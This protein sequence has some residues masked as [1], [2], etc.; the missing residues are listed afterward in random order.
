MKKIDL[1]KEG[2]SAA[3]ISKM[4]AKMLKPVKQEGCLMKIIKAPFRLLWWLIK[5]ILKCCGIWFIISMF[6]GDD[7]Q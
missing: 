2:K 3:K 6:T 5:L 1:V 7:D 4:D